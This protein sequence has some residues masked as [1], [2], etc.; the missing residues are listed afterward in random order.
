MSA[1]GLLCIIVLTSLRPIRRLWYQF[2]FVTHVISYVSLFIVINYHTPYA[3]PWIIPPVAFYA[4]DIFVRM[5]RFRIRDA[6]I[7]AF[8]QQLTLIQV[9]ACD[10]GWIAGQHVRLRAL[11]GGRVFEAHPL[12]IS[13]APPSISCTPGTRSLM[14]A[15]RVQGDWTKALHNL[16]LQN[17]KGIARLTVMID[18]PY[19]GSTIDLGEYEKVLLFAGGVGVT[20]TLGLLDDIVGRV[21]RLGRRGGEKTRV[22]EFAWCMRSFGCIAWFA[23]ALLDIANMA[24]GSSL[25][26]NMRCFVTCLCDPE[27]IPDIPNFEVLINDKPSVAELLR[28]L[29]APCHRDTEAKHAMPSVGGGLAIA[30]SGPLSLTEEAQNTV[31]GIKAADVRRVGGVGLHTELFCL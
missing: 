10:G 9:E 27:A 18:G 5:L 4:F 7:V 1:Y 12:T 30:A 25:Q 3:V 23:P 21:V 31:A 6:T 28:P 26:V 24:K 11:Y 15:A 14:L 19:G 2:F 29:L 22:I 20:F 16:A 17:E 8:D 13:N